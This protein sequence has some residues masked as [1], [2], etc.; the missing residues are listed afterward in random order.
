MSNDKMSNDTMPSH[1]ILFGNM[2]STQMSS[3]IIL[4]DTHFDNHLVELSLIITLDLDDPS[5]IPSSGF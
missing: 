5:W 4:D 3:D 2:L 1:Y